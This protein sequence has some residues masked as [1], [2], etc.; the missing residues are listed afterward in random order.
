LSELVGLEALEIA[1]NRF[2]GNYLVNAM[3]SF[4]RI[5]GGAAI[6]AATL[7]KDLRGWGLSPY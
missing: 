6:S 3:S 1:V 2:D 7:N 4:S 5:T